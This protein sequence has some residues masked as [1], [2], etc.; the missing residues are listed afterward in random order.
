M[1]PVC[2]SLGLP[3]GAGSL[4]SLA[5]SQSMTNRPSNLQQPPCAPRW[6]RHLAL[7]ATTA[8][9]ASSAR[10]RGAPRCGLLASAPMNRGTARQVPRPPGSPT[11]AASTPRASRARASRSRSTSPKPP[12]RSCNRHSPPTSRPSTPA[13]PHRQAF[14]GRQHADV[15]GH[16]IGNLCSKPEDRPSSAVVHVARHPHAFRPPSP[17]CHPPPAPRRGTDRGRQTGCDRD[18]EGDDDRRR[19]SALMRHSYEAR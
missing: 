10:H 7:T 12:G 16:R 9:T 19:I 2:I 3:L 13:V 8:T 14:A 5:L 6:T 4:L 1:L 15:L 18:S 17:T 11:S